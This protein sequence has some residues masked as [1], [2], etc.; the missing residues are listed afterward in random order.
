MKIAP[1]GSNIPPR[2]PQLRAPIPY[3]NARSAAE[4]WSM[5][6]TWRAAG[7][8]RLSF[9]PEATGDPEN[10][11]RSKLYNPLRWLKEFGTPEQQA[12]TSTLS[13]TKIGFE[14]VLTIKRPKISSTFDRAI[15]RAEQTPNEMKTP[16]DS[17]ASFREVER[18]MIKFMEANTYDGSTATRPVYEVTGVFLTEANAAELE[19]LVKD[20][21]GFIPLIRAGHRGSVRVIPCSEDEM[22]GLK[23]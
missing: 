5:L 8:Q 6:E 12:L 14:F 3:Y 17:S 13:W 7:C 2:A 4:F 21:G 1:P 9:S 22:K 20:Y 23:I 16:H 19:Q 10:T 18:D 15:T 11:L